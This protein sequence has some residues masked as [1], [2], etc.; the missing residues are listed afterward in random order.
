[1]LEHPTLAVE[2]AASKVRYHKTTPQGRLEAIQAR[3][4]DWRTVH[5]DYEISQTL[6][7]AQLIDDVMQGRGVVTTV[8]AFNA[9]YDTVLS[10]IQCSS[11]N[12]VGYTLSPAM[13]PNMYIVQAN[14]RRIFMFTRKRKFGVKV[15]KP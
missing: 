12:T 4:P 2:A 1:M 9:R 10:L 13:L 7:L 6:I 11:N 14:S 3:Y 15:V 5:N 8:G